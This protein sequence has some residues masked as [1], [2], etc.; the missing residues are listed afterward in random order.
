MRQNMEYFGKLI[1][2]ENHLFAI[3]FLGSSN[4]LSN[5]EVLEINIRVLNLDIQLWTR[6]IWV[7]IHKLVDDLI[8]CSMKVRESLFD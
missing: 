3:V 4:F 1:V 6:L 7:L 8:L 5:Y 2:V